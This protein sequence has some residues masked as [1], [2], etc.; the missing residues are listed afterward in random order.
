VDDSEIEGESRRVVFLPDIDSQLAPFVFVATG[1]GPPKRSSARFL[2]RSKSSLSASA[3]TVRLVSASTPVMTPPYG[4]F[5]SSSSISTFRLA[6]L[7]L[8]LTLTGDRFGILDDEDD[9]L[10]SV[11]V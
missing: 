4:I 1:P 6:P 9:A 2:L 3:I 7:I 5:S 11:F 10:G 8:S